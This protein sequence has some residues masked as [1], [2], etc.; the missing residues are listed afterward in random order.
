MLCALQTA[1]K[2]GLECLSQADVGSALQVRPAPPFR[3][4]SRLYE[5]IVR[6]AQPENAWPGCAQRLVQLQPAPSPRP[7][8][9]YPRSL[10]PPASPPI[11]LT[12]VLFNLNELQQAVM[13]L[14]DSAAGAF[15]RELAAALDPRKLSASSVAAGGG[16]VPGGA[17]SLGGGTLPGSTVKASSQESRIVCRIRSCCMHSPL[18]L[19]TLLP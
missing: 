2:A 10:R 12:Q 7:L 17:K 3:L 6:P 16:G 15:G 4:Q 9:P 8:P 19:A 11:K 5:C 13:Q 1:L 14:A 18:G